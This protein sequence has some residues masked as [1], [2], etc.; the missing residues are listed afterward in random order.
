MKSEVTTTKA[1]YNA[2]KFFETQ[3][4]VIKKPESLSL[5]Q[6]DIKE[7]EVTVLQGEFVERYKREKR[8]ATLLSK[9]IF[10]DESDVF[11]WWLAWWNMYVEWNIVFASYPNY[12]NYSKI[13]ELEGDDLV[14][15]SKWYFEIGPCG[16]FYL[17]IDAQSEKDTRLAWSWRKEKAGSTRKFTLIN[18]KWEIQKD[19]R[20]CFVYDEDLEIY[21]ENYEKDGKEYIAFYDRNLECL[22]D[23]PKWSNMH[24]LDEYR[25]KNKK[26][27]NIEEKNREE[28]SCTIK[29]KKDADAFIESITDKNWKIVFSAGHWKYKLE[30]NSWWSKGYFILSE[31][32]D[33]NQ[34]VKYIFLDANKGKVYEYWK[35]CLLIYWETIVN[36][37]GSETADIYT[38]DNKKIGELDSSPGSGYFG[39]LTFKNDNGKKQM[40]ETKTGKILEQE[41]DER[42]YMY[43]EE[44]EN[45]VIVK[46]G[47]DIL[48]LHIKN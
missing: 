1:P 2:D 10:W 41:F 36:F 32:W 39:S 26:E 11:L 33:N 23:A 44:N 40:V 47:D 16:D 34:E 7:K 30:N 38:I 6:E 24:I 35:E 31:I 5:V 37:T 3:E 18:K 29:R 21:T 8:I 48:E 9:K 20:W 19:L 22:S 27:E 4:N 42:L 28:K 46:N 13:Y 12:H 25:A 17:W 14:E 45:I 15:K 43:E